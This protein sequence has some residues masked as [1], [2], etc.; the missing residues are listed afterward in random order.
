MTRGKVT[1]H[2]QII[3]VCLLS[4][5]CELKT[6]LYFHVHSKNSGVVILANEK[7]I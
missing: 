4:D 1:D 7:P 2:Y 6:P 3:Q 5:C